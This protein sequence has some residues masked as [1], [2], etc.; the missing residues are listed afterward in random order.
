M[1]QRSARRRSG[2]VQAVPDDPADALY[3][4]SRVGAELAVER[5][6]VNERV[7]MR[8]FDLLR[9]WLPQR[10][11][12]FL[13]LPR[14][15]SYEVG[16]INHLLSQGRPDEQGYLMWT[17][18]RPGQKTIISS[19]VHE[20]RMGRSQINTALNQLCLVRLVQRILNHG[21]QAVRITDHF[22]RMMFEARW[23]SELYNSAPELTEKIVTEKNWKWLLLHA[24]DLFRILNPRKV[25][26]R[27]TA[28]GELVRRVGES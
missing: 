27:R 14:F 13:G 20:T 16:I 9:F 17:A 2:F 24:D 12:Q 26:D 25:D 28:L 10:Q 19:L 8:K 3:H 15:S 23:R 7:V 18:L 21:R 4:A 22:H 6:D 11:L 1:Q 5:S